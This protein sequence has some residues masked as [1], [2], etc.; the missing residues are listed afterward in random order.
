MGPTSLASAAN[1][2]IDDAHALMRGAA[3]LLFDLGVN[4][5][6]EFTLPCGRR[7]DL[8]GLGP[9]GEILIVEVKS[10]IADFRADRKWP[11]YFDWCDRFFFAVSDRFP[12][13]VLPGQTGLIVADAF[14]AGIVR[15]SPV[16]PLAPARRKALTLR[17][18]R[19]AAERLMRSL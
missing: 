12:H 16:Q 4:A 18:G 2:A 1:P 10:G 19:H 13:E 11:D 17:F 8:A 3:R 9:K 7:A 14:G 15:E 6:P 5:I